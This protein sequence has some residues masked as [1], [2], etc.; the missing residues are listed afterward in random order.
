MPALG[1]LN[2][3][4][5]VAVAAPHLSVERSADGVRVRLAQRPGA[6]A[7]LREAV[8]PV[9][10]VLAA[11]VVGGLGVFLLSAGGGIWRAQAIICLV[12]AV[13]ILMAVVYETCRNC[14]VVTEVAVDSQ[15]LV[16]RKANL[17]GGH[18][19][20]WPVATVKRAH[21]HGWCVRW[22][23]RRRI[24]ALTIDR[25]DGWPLRAF[26]RQPME[27]IK[28]AACALNRALGKHE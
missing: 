19:F 12:I 13:G 7:I 14:G 23:M 27:E 4:P 21:A 28:A 1:S 2:H 6:L 26:S 8:I 20:R 11:A 22:G 16:W 17:W 10:G 3:D 25:K 24:P 5:S 15:W 18:V 9:I